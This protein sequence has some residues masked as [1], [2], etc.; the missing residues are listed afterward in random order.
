MGDVAE[1]RLDALRTKRDMTGYTPIRAGSYYR[2]TPDTSI[3]LVS[4]S[5]EFFLRNDWSITL[6][7]TSGQD[8]HVDE[9]HLVSAAGSSLNTQTWY[10]HKSRYW[11]LGAEGALFTPG[12]RTSGGE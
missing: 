9:Y 6:G 11:E 3:G 1:L 12:E 8:D 7:G 5:I 4:P 10:R 2:Y